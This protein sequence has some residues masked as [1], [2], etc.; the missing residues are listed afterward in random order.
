MASEQE[1]K[2]HILLF[3]LCF[4]CHFSTAQSCPWNRILHPPNPAWNLSIP[5]RLVSSSKPAIFFN[6]IYSQI[7][8]CTRHLLKIGDFELHNSSK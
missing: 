1:Q 4:L 5:Q 6:L 7:I 8:K 3:C 2:T